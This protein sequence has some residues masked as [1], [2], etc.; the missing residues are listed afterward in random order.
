MHEGMNGTI[1]LLS[2]SLSEI[3]MVAQAKLGRDLTVREVQS[4]VSHLHDVLVRQ[5]SWP[6]LLRH[7]IEE[8]QVT[9]KYEQWLKEVGEEIWAMAACGVDDLP[10]FDYYSLFAV[11]STPNQAAGSVLLSIGFSRFE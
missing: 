5:S 4:L 3:Q 10:D 11:G 2:V 9:A 1:T 8:I 7:C 6:T